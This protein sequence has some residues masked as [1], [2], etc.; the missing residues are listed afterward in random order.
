[1]DFGTPHEDHGAARKLGNRRE[2]DPQSSWALSEQLRIGCPKKP[3]IVPGP[4]ELFF[5]RSHA[6]EERLTSHGDSADGELAPD[7]FPV[8]RPS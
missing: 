4:L 7:M 1:M 5:A 8:L 3:K 6:N 2:L